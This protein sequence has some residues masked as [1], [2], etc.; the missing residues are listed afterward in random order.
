MTLTDAARVALRWSAALTAVMLIYIAVVTPIG[1]VKYYGAFHIIT[2]VLGAAAMTSLAAC[3]AWV[4]RRVAGWG[5]AA[6]ISVAVGIAVALRALWVA[7]V[8]TSPTSDFLEYH[9]YATEVAHGDVLAHGWFFVV[10]PFKVVYALMLGGVY[11]ITTPQPYVAGV[12][13]II[14]SSGI[15]VMMYVIAHRVYGR[16]TARNASLLCAVWPLQI[17][18]T[19]VAAQ[20]HIF[21]LL[22]L[23][24]VAGM[25]AIPRDGRLMRIGMQAAA[26]GVTIALA[27]LFRPVAVIAFPVLIVFIVAMRWKTLSQRWIYRAATVFIALVMYSATTSLIGI[28]IERATGIDISKA[29]PGFSMYVGTHAPS[30][31]MWFPE[32]YNLVYRTAYNADTVHARSMQA[33]IE[34]VTA[35]PASMVV[36]AVEKFHYFWASG[37]YAVMYATR[38]MGQRGISP[39]LAAHHTS[40]LVA[41]QAIYAVLLAM[42][43][44]ALWRRR[45]ALSQLDV[46]VVATF[47]VHVAAFTLLEIQS[48][49][50]MVVE[51]MLLFPAAL[52]LGGMQ[53]PHTE[54]EGRVWE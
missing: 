29:R 7:L 25:L 47:L 36:L 39:I 28:P 41:S 38:E 53:R 43:G 15:V 21:L 3:A 26:I 8:D 49:Y 27:N 33:A 51:L 10:F 16:D 19:S 50:H 40:S 18:F 30:H 54:G 6:V 11:A 48:R 5:D 1:W 31:G 24:V 2:S 46:I 17:V 12:V 44:I 9:R 22:F 32:S 4:T 14:A 13:N 42:A 45:A 52:L 23:C 34:Q 37:E 35:D 20:E